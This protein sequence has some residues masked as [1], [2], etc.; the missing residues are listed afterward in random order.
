MAL[1]PILLLTDH[2]V[3]TELDAVANLLYASAKS[4]QLL[5]T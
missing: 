5:V 1:L 3:V 4:K 2:K